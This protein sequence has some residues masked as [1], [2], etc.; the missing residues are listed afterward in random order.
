MIR[1]MFRMMSRRHL[2]PI[3]TYLNEI[4]NLRLKRI[5]D[6]ALSLAALVVLSPVL[7]LALLV[8]LDSPW[9]IFYAYRRVGKDRR[10]FTFYKLCT[11]RLLAAYA[12]ND[13]PTDAARLTRLGRWLR[14]YYLD[15]VP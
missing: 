9:S 3:I 13:L 6:V 11:M 5:L 4:E 12:P 15:E 8:P 10:P 7:L 2:S 14:R 1:G